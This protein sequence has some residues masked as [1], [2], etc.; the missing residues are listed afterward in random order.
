MFEKTGQKS[1][2]AHFLLGFDKK[3]CVFSARSPSKLVHTLGSV[4]QNWMSQKTPTHI[5]ITTDLII[6]TMCIDT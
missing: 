2:F 6:F 5:N 1:L 4:G 3:K